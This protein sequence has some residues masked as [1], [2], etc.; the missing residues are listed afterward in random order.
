[1]KRNLKLFWFFS[2]YSIKQVAQHRTGI[3]FFMV[4]KV[5][6]FFMFF[7]FVFIL[8]SN[9]KV[10]AGY[11][12]TQTLVFFLT[13]NVID[14]LAQLLFREVYRFRPLVVSGEFDGVLVKP[15]HPLL[16]VLVGGV[17]VLDLILLVP[18]ILV[19]GF[20]VIKAQTTA[21]FSYLL[22]FMLLA[23]AIL[24]ATGFHILVL[25]LGILT[26]EVDHTIMIFRDLTRMAAVPVD[27]YRQPLRSVITFVIPIGIMMTF[28]VKG[29]FNLLSWQ[30]I[31]V[32]LA[33]GVGLFL[34]SLWSWQA[35]LRKYQS[36]GS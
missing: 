10:L 14:T 8:L 2:L 26:T 20:F 3:V 7:M 16:K 36:W 15:F 21:S 35:A 33:I 27:I 30:L 12:L 24:I 29:L 31:L 13:F 17:D 5:F 25:A 22:Y 19:L 11:T 23:N 4:G 28:P 34:V 32:S 1:M 18:Y 6:R 9:T